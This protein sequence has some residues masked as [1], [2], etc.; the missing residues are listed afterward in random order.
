MLED[1][2]RDSLRIHLSREFVSGTRDFQSC[3]V[4]APGVS[5]TSR[6]IT[7]LDFSPVSE[8]FAVVLGVVL[9]S[10]TLGLGFDHLTDGVGSMVVERSPDLVLG[11]EGLHYKSYKSWLGL[12]ESY[13][14]S[15]YRS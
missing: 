4:R 2:S 15:T 11:V 5:G 6:C 7:C 14:S 1:P 8:P 10:L 13:V 12:G 3:L 9:P